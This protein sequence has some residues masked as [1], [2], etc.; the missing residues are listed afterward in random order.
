MP[1]RAVDDILKDITCSCMILISF[2]SE[3][4]KQQFYPRPISRASINQSK[5]ATFSTLTQYAVL[6][7]L[8]C[9][10]PS[11]TS[12]GHEIV[13]DFCLELCWQW[14]D[15]HVC[16]DLLHP[17]HALPW[18]CIPKSLPMWKPAR[19]VSK[20]QLKQEPINNIRDAGK[21][22]DINSP[23]FLVENKWKLYWNSNVCIIT[24]LFKIVCF[25]ILENVQHL[26]YLG[27][28]C[29]LKVF[30]HN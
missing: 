8:H 30:A 1:L 5:R 10:M 15:S 13:R 21:V 28:Q 2:P 17:Q 16:A 19:V 23:K 24:S 27:I 6:L 26:E 9:P 3:W 20:L 25:I 29:S 12:R 18:L 11:S 7:S 22:L 14:D 4:Q